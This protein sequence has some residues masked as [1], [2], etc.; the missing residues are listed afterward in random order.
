MREI[1]RI[2]RERKLEFYSVAAATTGA[3]WLMNLIVKLWIISGP[4]PGAFEDPRTPELM[5]RVGGVL[6]AGVADGMVYALFNTA[7]SALLII[8]IREHLRGVTIGSLSA[9]GRAAPRLGSLMAA[10]I[11][12]FLAVAGVIVSAGVVAGL[13]GALGAA[14]A[15]AAGWSRA[16]MAGLACGLVTFGASIPALLYLIL[17]CALYPHA[18]VLEG[19]GPME[20]L[21][22]SL[23]LTRE[24]T[25][26][27]WWEQ[28]LFRA[29]ALSLLLIALQVLVGTIG[30]AASL[31]VGDLFAS[32]KDPALT[33]LLNPSGLPLPVLIPT[34]LF[35]VLL[36]ASVVPYGVGLFVLL[37][38]ET[39]ADHEPSRAS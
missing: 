26:R 15:T 38:L 24:I 36:A 16:A 30:L 39:S 22:R 27:A 13:V 34:E 4:G 17:R 28:Y 2:Y 9:L 23:T 37:Y 33:S 5:R 21:R 12:F 1:W 7:G 18:V 20:A 10:T 14:I 35:S 8:M 19:R 11:L 31:A 25:H 32:M 6:A 3:S 29:T